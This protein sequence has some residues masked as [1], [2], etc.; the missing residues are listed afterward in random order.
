MGRRG[1]RDESQLL[2]WASEWIPFAVTEK[3]EG[4]AFG[5]KKIRSLVLAKLT[6]GCLLLSRGRR[7]KVG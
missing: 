6:P 5:R 7:W 2:A 1:G 4:K 3:D